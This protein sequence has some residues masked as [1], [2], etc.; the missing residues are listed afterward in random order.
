MNGVRGLN[1]G[2]GMC[3]TIPQ[4][5]ALGDSSD[6]CVVAPHASCVG[7]G[8]PF[9]KP[10]ERNVGL[11][12]LHLFFSVGRIPWRRASH[13]APPIPGN[14][15]YSRWVA[16][17]SDAFPQCWAPRCPRTR[18]SACVAA[19]ARRQT[20]M[21]WLPRYA[22]VAAHRHWNGGRFHQVA[23]QSSGPDAGSRESVAPPQFYIISVMAA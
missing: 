14:C 18:N 4:E 22:A 9:S 15:F 20:W 3:L 11:V 16:A 12:G 7:Y 8:Q 21:A 10:A 1:L 6:G 17:L 13:I 23:M 2:P 5:W 19:D